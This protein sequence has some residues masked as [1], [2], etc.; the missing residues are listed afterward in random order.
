MLEALAFEMGWVKLKCPATS[1]VSFPLLHPSV[2]MGSTSA[3]RLGWVPTDF[4]PTTPKFPGQRWP[5]AQ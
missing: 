5:V 3:L 4:D 2:L 1:W